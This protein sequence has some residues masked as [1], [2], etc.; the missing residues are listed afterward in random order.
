MVKCEECH[1]WY[2]EEDLKQKTICFEE[3]FGVSDLF[4]TRTKTKVDCCP[5]CGSISL[6]E[7]EQCDCCGEWFEEL[8]DTSG[9]VNGDI[10]YI[11]DQCLKD[12]GCY[13]EEE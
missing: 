5:N 6:T 12:N 2:D 4:N 7:L 10:G 13:V 11:C 9:L 8:N 3:E 1:N